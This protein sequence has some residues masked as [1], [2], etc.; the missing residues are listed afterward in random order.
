M[1][2]TKIPSVEK[3]SA[4]ISSTEIL[5]DSLKAKRILVTGASCGLG[6]VCA[7]ALSQCGCRLALTARSS[8]KLEQVRSG[9]DNPDQHICLEADLTDPLQTAKTVQKAREFLKGI[10]VVVHAAGGGLGLRDP[11]LS[12]GDLYKLFALNIG[13]AAE[14]NRLVCPEMAKNKKGNLVHICS[15]AS[16]EATGSVGYN[17][18]KASLAAYVRSLGREMAE[19]GVVVTGILPGGFYAPENSW[20]RLESKNPDAVAKFVSDRLPRKFL[21]RA[22]EIVPLVLFLCSDAA[23]DGRLSGAH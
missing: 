12:S 23:S 16:S 18:V 9:C 13:A 6:S 15:I 5:Q 2:R 22:E 21:G 17:T 10:D 11:L 14:I 19:Q 3:I 1:P 4:G 20:R 7:Q 8:D